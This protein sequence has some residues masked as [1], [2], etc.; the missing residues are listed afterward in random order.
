MAAG[1]LFVPV[2]SC[3]LPVPRPGKAQE[4]LSR[5][6]CPVYTPRRHTQE[7]CSLAWGG[8]W[9][10]HICLLLRCE[11]LSPVPQQRGWA[12]CG[13]REPGLELAAWLRSLCFCVF[14]VQRCHERRSITA[15]LTALDE[16]QG[17]VGFCTWNPAKSSHSGVQGSPRSAPDFRNFLRLPWFLQ[18][19]GNAITYGD[20]LL[21]PHKGELAL[22]ISV[23]QK[24]TS[25]LN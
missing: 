21:V 8:M 4:P 6:G 2:S 11:T 24:M 10:P 13:D 20:S 9:Y 22:S 5:P 1:H 23:P 3:E 15:S 16:M 7:G 17:R 18:H 12:Q 25:C 19:H 14:S